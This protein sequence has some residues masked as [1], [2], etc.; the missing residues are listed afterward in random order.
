[1]TEEF[2]IDLGLY[3][4]WSG[5]AEDG[6][7][8]N[9]Q[10]RALTQ[11]SLLA[12]AKTAED[13]IEVESPPKA[14]CCRIR[15]KDNF[16]IDV[17]V[18]HLDEER[19]A[20][21]LA[22]QTSWESSDPKA[23]YKWFKELFDDYTREKAR[24]HVRYLKCWAALKFERISSRPSSVLLT[25]LAAE[26]MNDLKTEDYESDDDGFRNIVAAIATRISSATVVSN[27]VEPV[28]NLVRLSA[29]DLEIFRRQLNELARTASAA[30]DASNVLEAASQWTKAFEHLFPM[31]DPQESATLMSLRVG[32]PNVNVFARSRQNSSGTWQGTNAI[33]PIPKDCDIDF[34]VAEPWMLPSGA[35]VEWIVRNRDDEAEGVNDLGHRAGIGLSAREQSAYNG[36]H[37]MDCVVK[38]GGHA[39]A[40]RRIAVTIV[41]PFM[42]RAARRAAL[43]KRRA[44]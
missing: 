8:T 29:S 34:Q 23:I 21:T 41:G 28:E 38:V 35:V 26:A 10:L 19:D 16:H 31:P 24:R 25:V 33:G 39:I 4:Q 1:M 12:Y 18:Y 14:R 20:R 2:D 42:N 30:G 11:D 15:F 17:P 5:G 44:A 3:F 9:A 40:H 36:T 22:A 37:F 7:Y 43:A 32:P 13:V 6:R 27:P